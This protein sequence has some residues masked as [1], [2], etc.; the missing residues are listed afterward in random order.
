LVTDPSPVLRP[1]SPQVQARQAKRLWVNNL[2]LDTLDYVGHFDVMA[3]S[4][5]HVEQ[6]KSEP[7]H[8]RNLIERGLYHLQPTHL[9]RVV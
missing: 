9:K 2:K 1:P 4:R 5:I 7:E 8:R 3:F 6:F